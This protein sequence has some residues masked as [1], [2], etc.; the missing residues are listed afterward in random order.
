MRGIVGFLRDSPLIGRY[1]RFRVVFALGGL[2][3][4][5]G[6]TLFG[7]DSLVGI[8]AVFTLLLLVLAG[9][10]VALLLR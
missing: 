5:I 9:V 4:A 10:G 7:V 6:V 3:A 1:I 8:L 2:L